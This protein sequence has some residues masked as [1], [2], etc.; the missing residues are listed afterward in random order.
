LKVQKSSEKFRKVQKSS[1]KFRKVQKR[2]KHLKWAPPLPLHGQGPTHH[3][4]LVLLRNKP[5]K[6]RHLSLNA[7]TLSIS[8]SMK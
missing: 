4:T 2:S 6:S 8:A 3:V 7:T 1:E 5:M